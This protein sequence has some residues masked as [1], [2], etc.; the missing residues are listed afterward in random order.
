MFSSVFIFI[1]YDFKKIN[2]PNKVLYRL[3]IARN[4]SIF[5][6]FILLLKGIFY[7]PFSTLESY[8]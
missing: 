8:F 7:V 5:D 1:K 3:Y 4:V 2:G 6:L